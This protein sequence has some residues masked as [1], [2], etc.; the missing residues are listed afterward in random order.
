MK[1]HPKFSQDFEVSKYLTIES[2]EKIITFLEKH[3]GF[4]TD[5]IPQVIIHLLTI[6]LFHSCDIFE[7][8][9]CRKVIY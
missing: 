2:F 5:L 6:P 9:S 7:I 1:N 3:T 8:V 4:A